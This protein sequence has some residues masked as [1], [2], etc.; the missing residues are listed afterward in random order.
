MRAILY[1]GE[2]KVTKEETNCGYLGV[3]RYGWRWDGPLKY[4]TRFA[5]AC[6]GMSRM[7]Y[8]FYGY[9]DTV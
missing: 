9:S 1:C 6:V 7:K 5:S 2:G 8:L 4:R 3:E